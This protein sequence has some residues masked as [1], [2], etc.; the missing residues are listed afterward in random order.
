MR[1]GDPVGV[2]CPVQLDPQVHQR[3]GQ[4]PAVGALGEGDFVVGVEYSAAIVAVDL[5]DADHAVGV[6]LGGA[7]GAHAGRADDGDVLVEGGEDLL[8]PDR[9]A[10]VPQSIED[11]HGVAGV[12][13]EAEEVA[14]L[15]G[16]VDGRG[17]EQLLDA[18]GGDGRAG[19][20]VDAHVASVPGRGRG[21]VRRV[22]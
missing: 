1:T 21:T 3:L 13:R 7:Q 14:V 8:V 6:E 5:A 12:Q 22:S 19:E 4:R 16:R 2:C 15:D 20:D 18:G 9:R 11:Q 17:R 10:V